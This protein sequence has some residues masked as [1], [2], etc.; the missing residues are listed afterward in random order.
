MIGEWIWD[1]VLTLNVISKNLRIDDS[2]LQHMK[3]NNWEVPELDL[4]DPKTFEE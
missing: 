3:D 2:F 1:D 4:D